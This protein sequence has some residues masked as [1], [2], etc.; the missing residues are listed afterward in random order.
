MVSLLKHETRL[1]DCSI[2]WKLNKLEGPRRYKRSFNSD[3]FKNYLHSP[4]AGEAKRTPT[5][6]WRLFEVCSYPL[7]EQ[8]LVDFKQGGTVDI[9]AFYCQRNHTQT[10]FQWGNGN[11][12]ALGKFN[13]W[14]ISGGRWVHREDNNAWICSSHITEIS[15]PI[16]INQIIT[17]ILFVIYNNYL[18]FAYVESV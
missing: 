6:S 4:K 12:N 9:F 13:H 16:A 15:I 14:N 3:V 2:Q 8:S 7:T 10:L 5:H 1:R 18:L 17:M 11:V